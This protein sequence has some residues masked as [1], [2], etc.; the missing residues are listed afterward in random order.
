M[1]DVS[2]VID[3]TNVRSRVSGEA[4]GFFESSS[5]QLVSVGAASG[6]AHHVVLS[7]VG[8]D[9]MPGSP[10]MSAKMMQEDIVRGSGIP[11]TILRTTQFFDFVATFDELFENQGEVR[12][13]G[14]LMRPV[15]IEEV[16]AALTHV[17]ARPPG[18]GIVE[19]GGPETMSIRD[20]V[21]RILDA[22]GDPRTVR[23]SR[24][25]SYFGATLEE[26]TLLPAAN[27]MRGVVTLDAWLSQM[28]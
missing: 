20:A 9:R 5:R 28:Q 13:P 25:I 12:V 27:A 17:A 16:V 11:F 7:V 6:V 10:Y 1:R 22:R 8:A 3:V 18:Q 15:A 21:Q 2:L 19:L 4:R 23:A 14:A 26:D 24:S